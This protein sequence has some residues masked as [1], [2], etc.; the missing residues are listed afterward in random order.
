MAHVPEAEFTVIAQ[1]DAATGMTARG[2]TLPI[3]AETRPTCATSACH[4]RDL[5][6]EIRSSTLPVR[7][8]GEGEGPN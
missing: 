6:R 3:V 7:G 4:L 8:M 1:M 5:L 2:S